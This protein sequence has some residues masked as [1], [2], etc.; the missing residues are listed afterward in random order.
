MFDIVS[1]PQAPTQFTPVAGKGESFVLREAHYVSIGTFFQTILEAGTKWVMIGRIPEGAV[2]RSDDQVLTV[3][4]SNI[5][6]AALVVDGGEVVGFYLL[7]EKTF[8]PA[9]QKTPLK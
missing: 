4:A 9:Q 2:Y 5:H 6:E 8:C 1:V 3:E 7:V